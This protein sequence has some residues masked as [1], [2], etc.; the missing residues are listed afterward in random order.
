MEKILKI[1]LLAYALI[2]MLS[3]PYL[4]LP[5]NAGVSV[6]IFFI[7]QLVCLYFILPRKKP[8]LVFSPIFIL[9]LNSF[10]YGNSMWRIS[11][12]I[13]IILL[14]A[15]MILIICNK[16]NFNDNKLLTKILN[17]VFSPFAHFNIPFKW[18][19]EINR[20]NTTIL[21]RI[22]IALLISAPVLI[23]MVILLSS[24]DSIFSN[25][26]RSA[27]ESFF[28]LFDQFF[29]NVIFKSVYGIFMGFYG[30][31]LVVFAYK[32]KLPKPKPRPVYE[33]TYPDGST[34]VTTEVPEPKKDPDKLIINI[35]LSMILL[36]YTVFVVIQFA[37]LF[38]GADL[39]YG[40]T[41]TEYAR[42]GFF[43]LLFL[44]GIN[45]V[46]IL[47]CTNL[48]K[49]LKANITKGL[50][51]YLCAVTVILLVSSYYRMM[52]YN[53]DDGLTRLRFLV[54]GFLIFEGLGLIFTFY[55]IIKPRFS[56]ISVYAAIALSYY[57][58]LNLVPIDGIVAKSQMDRGFNGV[59]Y[60]K[61][62]SS[63]AAGQILRLY[64]HEEYR[65][66]AKS[67]IFYKLEWYERIPNR[68]QRYNL[69]VE[70]LKNYVEE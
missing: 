9:S 20:E 7:I 28:D 35:F 4:I 12:F 43:E 58:I 68:W 16:F 26:V 3:F 21:K 41:Y 48:T 22:L 66:D 30:F 25:M 44:T 50:L 40:L 32:D 62:L 18:C 59:N 64:E 57:L 61:T 27:F 1:K 60:V 14:Y 33:Y 56:I 13:V 49:N 55:Y 23:F 5:E 47:V 17:L 11:N 67:F 8:L 63:D 51:S 37:Y 42:K 69:S 34:L 15:V 19:G 53:T 39:P 70:R 31:G 52:L 10:I 65:D 45:I 38:T 46:I 54:F 36:L 2:T 29:G 6:P 24:A